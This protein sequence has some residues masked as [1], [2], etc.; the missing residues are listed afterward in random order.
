MAS[1]IWI[2]VLVVTLVAASSQQAFINSSVISSEDSYEFRCEILNFS[3]SAIWKLNNI[4][5]GEF[6]AGLPAGIEKI[7]TTSNATGRVMFSRII[8]P[9]DSHFH[10]QRLRLV[11]C[12][13]LSNCS[14]SLCTNGY[15][16]L[17]DCDVSLTIST[18]DMESSTEQT[19]LDAYLYLLTLCVIVLCTYTCTIFS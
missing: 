11:C 15:M 4:T 6:N 19:L 17:V 16:D 9:K 3:R 12:R 1:F 13:D 2:L 8:I 5:L 10:D 18:T 14:R 7:Q